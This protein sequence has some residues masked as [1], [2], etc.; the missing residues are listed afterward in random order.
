MALAS[1]TIAT[2]IATLSV[3]GVTFKDVTAIPQEV[4]ARDCPIIF[5]QPAGWMGGGQGAPETTTTFGTPSTRYW[6]V[7]RSYNYVY[8]YGLAGDA[9]GLKD[10][11]SAAAGYVDDIIEAVTALNVSGVDVTGI[12]HTEV[13]IVS[14]P[15]GTQ[16]VGCLFTFSLRERI[17]A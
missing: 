8:L 16:F 10:Q 12:S 13:G 5:P 15:A 4:K 9:R 11:Y 14:D 6:Q 7:T 3:S 1:G 17:N 2:A